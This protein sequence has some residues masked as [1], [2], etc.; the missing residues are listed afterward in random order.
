MLRAVLLPREVEDEA[1]RGCCNVH[2]PF[3]RSLPRSQSN[4]GHSLKSPLLGA[5][6]P[7][8]E[9]PPARSSSLAAAGGGAVAPLPPL[10]EPAPLRSKNLTG[11]QRQGARLTC[12]EGRSFPA[13]LGAALG[14]A[15]SS[16]RPGAWGRAG[17]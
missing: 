16:R 1:A 7:L 14:L 8:K 9:A 11:C 13:R 12:G 15:T 17:R 5:A 6:L 10:R 4:A 2:H 3:C